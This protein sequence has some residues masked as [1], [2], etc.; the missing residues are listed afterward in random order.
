[1][2]GNHLKWRA[3]APWLQARALKPASPGRLLPAM[4]ARLPPA[5]LISLSI[6]YRER[7]FD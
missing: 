5:L 4:A 3:G 1:M 2:P 6:L 7:R